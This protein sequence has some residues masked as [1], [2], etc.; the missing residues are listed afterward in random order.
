MSLQRTF[1]DTVA[2]SAVCAAY[3][4]G[5]LEQLKHDGALDVTVFAEN[6]DL[7]LPAVQAI[8]QALAYCDVAVYDGAQKIS[9]GPAL[10]D[11]W[12]HKGYFLWLVRGYGQLLSQAGHL[13]ANTVRHGDFF[14]RDGAA[15]AQAGRDY[16]AQFVDPIFTDLVQRLEFTHAADLGCGSAQ[17]LLTLASAH[18]QA[19]FIGIDV[20]PGAVEV[21]AS[22]AQRHE[23]TDRVQ[24]HRDDVRQ[25]SYHPDHD[26]VDLVFCFFLGHDFWPRGDCLRTLDHIREAFPDVKHFLLSDT[27]RA[28]PTAQAHNTPIFT[29]GFEYTHALMGHYLPTRDEWLEVFDQSG[30]HLVESHPLGIPSSETFHLQPS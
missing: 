18:P 12:L 1:N 13:S 20:D 7:H 8:G 5:L 10:D 19:R 2:A 15:I 3:E 16:G 14:H 23:L 4:L 27:Y 28:Q 25:V 21:A 30:W 6:R 22:A 9:A 29:L 17:R 24:I 11:A 26:G